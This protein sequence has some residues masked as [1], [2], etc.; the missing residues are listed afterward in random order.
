MSQLAAAV[1]AKYPGS[2]DHLSD[3]ELEKAVVAKYPGAYDHLL[4][5]RPSGGASGSWET[6]ASQA[7][8]LA[9]PNYI[10]PEAV[11]AAGKKVV[12]AGRWVKENP[13]TA[14]SIAGSLAAAPFTGGMSIPAMIALET[15]AAA[16]GHAAGRILG[17]VTQGKDIDLGATAY[18]AGKEGLLAGATAGLGPAFQGLARGTYHLALRPRLALSHTPEEVTRMVTTGLE[19]GINVSRGGFQKAGGLIEKQ[20]AEV[21]KLIEGLNAVGDHQRGLEKI[22]A[23]KRRWAKEGALDEQLRALDDVAQQYSERFGASGASSRLEDLHERK[24]GIWRQTQNNWD[25]DM[26]PAK[27]EAQKAYGSGLRE[28]IETVAKSRGVDDIGTR[29]ERIGNL[30]ELQEVVSGR[31]AHDGIPGLRQGIEVPLG[32]SPGYFTRA[33]ATS[34]LPLSA[35]ARGMNRV[36]QFLDPRTMAPVRSHPP[37]GGKPKTTQT[38]LD[39]LGIPE[40]AGPAYAPDPLDRVGVPVT[41]GAA[42]V[43]ELWLKKFA[44]EPAISHRV[45]Y[46]PVKNLHPVYAKQTSL[47]ELGIPAGEGPGETAVQLDALDI[48]VN[49]EKRNPE[50][51]WLQRILEKENPQL[52]KLPRAEQIRYIE[53]MMRSGGHRSAER[54]TPASRITKD[55]VETLYRRYLTSK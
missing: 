37:I 20:A 29:N 38:S 53:E 18:E 16:G 27:K 48:P 35:M 5:Q 32:M 9:D 54:N 10:S 13:G 26:G 45:E 42:D 22:A 4:E 52:A 14:G 33:V 49:Q 11:D 6:P 40:T 24:Q 12:Q 39:A 28:E 2:Y 43:D 8:A 51:L 36:G 31:A 34:S 50:E 1:R 55:K 17:D 25:T 23:L 3:E 19:E 46:P 15:A 30:M 21:K 41:R 7:E 47:D 44:P